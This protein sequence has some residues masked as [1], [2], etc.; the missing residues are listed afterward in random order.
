LHSRARRP[1]AWHHSE[2]AL[3]TGRKSR[4][5]LDAY[6]PDR[7]IVSR[8]LTQFSEVDL[9][10]AKRY[11]NEFNAKYPAGTTIAKT[12][13]NDALGISGQRLRGDM[14]LEVPP[15][16]GGTVDPAIVAYARSKQISIRG[17]NGHYYT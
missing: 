1:T 3:T 10:T 17:I 9:S 8:K 4:I 15:Q 12:R 13:K 6:T 7:A 16:V 11:I 14:I 2:I 5:R